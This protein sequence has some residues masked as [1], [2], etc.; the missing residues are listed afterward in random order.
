MKNKTALLQL[1]LFLTLMV[2]SQ[3][4]FAKGTPVGDISLAGR[5]ER[6]GQPLINDTTLFE[7]DI[8]KTLANSV[9]VIRIGRGRL[10]LDQKT[11]VEIVS[12]KPLKVVVKSGSLRFNFPV[13]T[14]FEI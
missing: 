9:G 8:V 12:E 6:S 5:V 14:D 11:E 4:V 1:G 13:G 2:C 10:D 7:G 3:S